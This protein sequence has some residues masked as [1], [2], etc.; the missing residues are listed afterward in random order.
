MTTSDRLGGVCRVPPS[1]TAAM[2]AGGQPGVRT[3][4]PPGGHAPGRPAVSGGHAARRTA[5]P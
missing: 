4:K 2:T 5:A 3:H 1:L